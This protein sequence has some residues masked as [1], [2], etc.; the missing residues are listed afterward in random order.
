MH[1]P[2]APGMPSIPRH[3]LKLRTELNLTTPWSIAANVLFASKAHARGDENNLD[4]NGQVP[5]YALL[6]FDTRYQ[7]AKN[8]QLFARIDNVLNR[9]YA[10]FGVL[11]DNVFTGPSQGFDAANP[12]AEQFRGNGTPRGAWAGVQYAFE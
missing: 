1:V 7:V 3:T 12:R 6:N 11:G 5:G 4:V 10:N 8:L 2:D 9:R